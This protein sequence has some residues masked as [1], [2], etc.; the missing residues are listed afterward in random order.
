MEKKILRVTNSVAQKLDVKKLKEPFVRG[1]AARSNVKGNGL[2][3][4]LADQAA[5]LNGF[6]LNL[7]CTDKTFTAELKM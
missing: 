4:S 1:D 2:G 6:K 7:N 5:R 3:L